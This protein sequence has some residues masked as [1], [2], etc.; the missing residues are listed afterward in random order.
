MSARRA[1][2]GRRERPLASLPAGVHALLGI[3][4][5]AQLA[6]HAAIP[7]P[8]AIAAA[9]T[10]PPPQE[11]LQVASLGEPVVLGKLM[12]LYL[13]AFDD[14]PGISI[15]FRELDYTRVIA[16]LERILALDPHS[17]YALLSASRLYAE[18]PVESKQ[19]M[20]LEFV[21]RA[22]LRDPDH[23]WRWLAHGVILAK[24]RLHDLPL[25]MR[26][27]QAIRR[28]AT[29]PDVPHW[30]TQMEIFVLEDMNEIDAARVILGGLIASGRITEPR[31]LDFLQRRQAAL[32][33]RAAQRRH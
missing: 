14:Q 13:Q 25:A 3:A 19:R 27:A 12:M 29:G 26:Y 20:M 30:A 28:F 23:R 6:T 7:P 15:P 22:F 5:A 8:R 4:F 1:R 16:W 11:I 10:D 17:D 9:L 2:R 33:E 21:Y 18:V 24:H 32:E 31:E